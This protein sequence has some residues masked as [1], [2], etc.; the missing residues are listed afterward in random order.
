MKPIIYYDSNHYYYYYYP[1]YYR[2]SIS[3]PFSCH[4]P[5]VPSSNNQKNPFLSS[6][7]FS[8]K[9]KTQSF[10]FYRHLQNYTISDHPL[11]TKK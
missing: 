5:T 11:L 2:S 6:I 1:Y 9:L 4:L 7:T 3:H 8:L 10:L